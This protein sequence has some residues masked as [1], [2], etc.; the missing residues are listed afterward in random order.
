MPLKAVLFDFNGV[1]VNDE[2]IHSRILDALLLE[3][4]LRPN[5]GECTEICLGRSDRVCLQE[6]FA[7][8]ERVLGDRDLE[9]LIERKSQ[10]YRAEI[11]KLGQTPVFAGVSD[12]VYQFRV[13]ELKLAVVSGALRREIEAVLTSAQLR[14]YFSLIVAGDDIPTSKPDPTGY[15][16]AIE[17]L[18]RLYPEINLTAGDCLAIED[19]WAGITAAKR[20]GISVVGVAHTY[21]FHMMQRWANWAIDYL[22]DLEVER[23]LRVFEGSE[24]LE[25]S[26]A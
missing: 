16:L 12:L 15:L 10:L 6:L 22:N 9:R 13:A 17:Q 25:T 18:A 8:R 24:P 11:E 1:I 2:A 23:V 7:R 20:A 21:P 26:A 19:T 4:N 5:P 3:E 14:D